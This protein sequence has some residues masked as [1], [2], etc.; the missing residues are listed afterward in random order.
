MITALSVKNKVEFIYR[1]FP[2]PAK[3]DTSYSSWNKCNNMVVSWILHPV[4]CA[5]LPKNYLDGHCRRH[6]ERFKNK[7]WPR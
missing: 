2:Q 6:F 4:F 3:I 1:S 7:I 5:H